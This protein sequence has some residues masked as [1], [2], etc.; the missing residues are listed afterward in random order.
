MV[1]IEWVTFW[2]IN[3]PYQWLW[4]VLWSARIL[5][6][7]PQRNGWSADPFLCCLWAEKLFPGQLPLLRIRLITKSCQRSWIVLP[8][9]SWSIFLENHLLA[10]KDLSEDLRSISLTQ[11]AWWLCPT[12]MQRAR[13]GVANI[14]WGRPSLYRTFQESKMPEVGRIPPGGRWPHSPQ[15]L[16][17][18][19]WVLVPQG[20]IYTGRWCVWPN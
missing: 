19:P 10:L 2:Y 9:F 5:C 6:L 11:M 7:G 15:S 3:E 12:P 8:R 4:K 1:H 17:R 14:C 16:P 18:P 20:C 13:S